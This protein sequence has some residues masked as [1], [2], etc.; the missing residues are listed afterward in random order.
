MIHQMDPY[1]DLLR[2]FA[3]SAVL[4]TAQHEPQISQI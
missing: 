2:E 4:A 3:K 1:I